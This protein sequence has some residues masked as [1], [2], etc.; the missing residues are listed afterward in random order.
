MVEIARA[1]G[2]K[3]W[4]KSGGH[5]II[6]QTGKRDPQKARSMLTYRPEDGYDIEKYT[7]L[8]LKSV[9]TLLGPFGY[10]LPRLR[11][12]FGIGRPRKAPKRIPQTTSA[13]P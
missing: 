6:D 3:V 1:L 11:E 7:E 8:L 4:L 13:A 5:I 10:D 12:H 2:R 9:E